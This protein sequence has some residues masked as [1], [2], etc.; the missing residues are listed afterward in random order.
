MNFSLFLL[1]EK[2]FLNLKKPVSVS[3]IVDKTFNIY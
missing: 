3:K 2:D 1:T